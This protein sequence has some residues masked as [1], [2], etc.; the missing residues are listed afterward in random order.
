MKTKGL[1][2]T[3]LW[4][5]AALTLAACTSDDVAQDKEKKNETETAKG[6]TFTINEPK[7]AA[8]ARM[9]AAETWVDAKTRTI[10]KHWPGY[11][12]D[13]YWT[14]T[15]YIYVRDHNG[16]W[17]KSTAIQLNDGGTSA[18][19]TL[20]NATYDDGCVVNYTMTDDQ[21]LGKGTTTTIKNVQTQTNVN[22]F[23]HAAAS[24]D[25]GFGYARATGN[26]D[27]FNFTL[28]HTPSYL[29]FIPRC[30][31]EGLGQNIELTKITVTNSGLNMLAAIYPV[32]SVGGYG[33]ESRYKTITLTTGTSTAGFP[34]TNTSDSHW[35]NA[36][37]MV[38]GT[39]AHN[40]T[41]KYT[42]R[43]KDN[44]QT[45]DI[46]QTI[47]ENFEA[48]KIYDIR[49]NL[50]PESA[51][52][53]KY[54]MW[55]AQ[56]DYWHGHLNAYGEPDGNYPQSNSD[57][58][59]YNEA[60]PGYEKPNDAQ[61]A[62]FKTLPNVNELWW[63]VVHGDAHWEDNCV[64]GVKDNH[65]KL[66]GGGLW[67]RKKS[68]ILAHIKANGYPASLTEASLKAG[69][70]FSP[71][72]PLE[73]MRGNR[74]ATQVNSIPGRPAN[75]AD[76]FFLPALAWYSNGW[77]QGEYYGSHG[78]YWTSNAYPGYSSNQAFCLYFDHNYT[79]MGTFQ[80]SEGYTARPFE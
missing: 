80:R 48:G 43:D 77:R 70:M 54:Y 71:T 60:Y 33:W 25:C 61:T 58:R 15:D 9:T 4:G 75:T 53:A 74:F 46:T 66:I 55:D 37:Y 56:Q 35:I 8:K 39:G 72:S 64:V 76:Y 24:G 45:T 69:Y 12:A 63:Y 22:D 51:G 17:Q 1:I 47:N 14:S 11:G 18:T 62:F 68:A 65:L 50:T 38:I 52:E 30:E 21:I 27:K 73:D 44:G 2:K 31:N 42:I 26:P 23:S 40:L 29:C 34:L 67:L 78:A 13:A 6:I 32:G 5:I 3:C 10:I 59:W 16:I 57:P 49:A 19:F 20:P 7:G 28:K 79:G 41:I 36:A